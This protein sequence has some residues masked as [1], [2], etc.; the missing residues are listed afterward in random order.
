VWVKCPNPLCARKPLTSLA[1]TTSHDHNSTQPD[2][3]GWRT[4]MHSTRNLQRSRMWTIGFPEPSACS[5]SVRTHLLIAVNAARS[6]TPSSR[7][8]YI[9]HPQHAPFQHQHT[10]LQPRHYQEL[11]EHLEQ[12]PGRIS[13]R[14]HISQQA[15][16][17]WLY[18]TYP[19]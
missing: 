18:S 1:F 4:P 16:R 5:S 7:H 14:C 12:A 19:P 15:H 9:L 3:S 13:R 10:R 8:P 17:R 2:N 6:L 11:T